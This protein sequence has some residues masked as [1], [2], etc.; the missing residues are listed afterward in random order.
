[1]PCVN[2]VG[3]P[4][5]A[6]GRARRRPS[7]RRD[8]GGNYEGERK[9]K[10]KKDSLREKQNSPSV[11]CF[12]ECQKLGNR[13]E[14]LPRVLHSGKNNTRG[15]ETSPSAVE[16]MALGK[17]KFVFDGGGKQSRMVKIFPECLTL[18]LGETSLFPE[19]LHLALRE[20][21]LFPECPALTLGE[22]PFPG[23]YF[24]K[25]FFCPIFL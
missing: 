10:K 6:A 17:D 25:S 19:C 12:P 20:A 13:G 16:S 21:S 11:S 14:N 22:G 9:S 2:V 24:F 18:A 3:T 7:I 1:M 5:P 8:A 15:R 4:R 23:N